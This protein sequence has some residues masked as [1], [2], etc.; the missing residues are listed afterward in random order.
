MK[1]DREYRHVLDD[2]GEVHLTA[3]AGNATDGAQD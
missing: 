1:P 3:L 2:K